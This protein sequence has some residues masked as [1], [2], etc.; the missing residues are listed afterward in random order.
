VS[1]LLLLGVSH[2]TAPLS[3]RERVALLAGQQESFLQDLVGTRAIDEAVVISTCNRTEVYL[4]VTD[5]VHAETAALGALASRAGIRPTE[6]AEVVYAPRNCDAARQLYRVTAGLESMIVGEAEVQGQVRRA[7]ES[8]VAART[9][10]PLT[11]RLFNSAL[12]TGGRVRAETAIGAG[13]ASISSVAVDLAQETLG[14]L[15][16]RHV[17]I[18]GAGETAELTARALAA[19]GVTTIFVANRHA[20]RAR[21]LAERF[22][23]SVLALDMLPDQ[24][25]RADM[26]VA[27]TASPHAILEEDELGLV[28]REREGRP[29]LLLDIAV[30]RDVEPGVGELE[31]ITLVDVDGLQRVVRRNL[32]VRKAEARGAE[33]IVEE[34]L[35]RFAEWL[36]AREVM[37]TVGALRA[38]ALGIV[39]SVLAENAARWETDA[40]RVRAE[41][42]ARA[43][44]NR[45]LHEPTARLKAQGGHA[46]LQIARELFGL[47]EG[48]AD[49][50]EA[51]EHA[52]GD[53]VRELRR[54]RA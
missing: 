17:V 13:G 23:G 16:D 1:E 2:K 54:R 25:V 3:L 40:D 53:N 35:E 27:S 24:L 33:R 5:Q 43:V 51:A 52:A 38:H 32:R 11:N 41:A 19:K 49:A 48:A 14:D 46:R 4:V 9:N 6:L 29:L 45:L 26:V 37:P 50:A 18:I 47:E 10:G 28:M 7:Y 39:E 30:P 31:G 15:A 34:E 21:S 42:L 44:M 22:G 36:S 8:A 12:T 20:A